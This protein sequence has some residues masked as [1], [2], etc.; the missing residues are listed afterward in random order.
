MK[1][2]LFALGI[3]ALWFASRVFSIFVFEGKLIYDYGIP[4]L[5][6]LLCMSVA[7][8]VSRKHK[9]K[10]A[11]QPLAWITTWTSVGFLVAGIL[12]ITAWVMNNNIV[13]NNAGLLWPFSLGLVALDGHPSILAGLLVVAVMSFVN[14]LYYALLALLSWVLLGALRRGLP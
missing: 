9:G 6:L 5:F 3:F 4:T 13:K 12:A 11:H 2:L 8:W 14:G 10:L 7:G 1:W